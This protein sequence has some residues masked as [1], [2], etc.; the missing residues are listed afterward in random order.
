MA[1]ALWAGL[2]CAGG[3]PLN[4]LVVVNDNSPASLDAGR[5]YLERRG[6]PEASLLHLAT[7]T[8][9]SI[10][11][12]A[13]SN[14][15]RGPVLA[16]LAASG[17]SN[18]VDFIVFAPDLPYRVYDGA[19]TNY[20][21]ASLTAAL[22]DDVRV[23]PNA[24]VYGCD[25]AAD[26]SNG[27]YAAER[28]FRH[29]GATGSNRYYLCAQLTASNLD[30]ARRLIDRA[31]AADFTQPTS[32]VALLHTSDYF[33]NI[34]WPLFEDADFNARLLPIPQVREILDADNLSGRTNLIGF[35][36]GERFVSGIDQNLIAPGAFADHITSY[37]GCLFDTHLM[38]L[39]TLQ[40][41]I[42]AWIQAGYCGAYGTVV[43]P[44]AIPGKFPVPMLHTWYARGFSLGES[45][46]MSLQY[47]YQ[48]IFVGDPLCA[49]FAAPPAVTVH[50]LTPGLVVTGAVS[51]S[52]T[53]TAATAAARVDRIDLYLDG[54]W[55]ATATNC[56]PSAS[57]R[58][59]LSVGGATATYAVAAG[60]DIGKVAAG[61]AAAVNTSGAPVQAWASGDRVAL[62]YTNDGASGSGITCAA[63]ADAGGAPLLTVAAQA[64]G[65]NLLDGVYPAREFIG[66]AGTASNGD[67][68]A[69]LITLT[70]GAVV[71]NT[72]VASAGESAASVLARLMALVNSNAA[73]Q[74]TDGVVAKYWVP[75]A[76]A[77]AAL[78]ARTPG[79][80]GFN[81]QVDYRVT[82]AFPGSGLNTN[83][84]F[85]DRF[86]DNLSVLRARGGVLISAGR[87]ALGA[88]YL[89]AT[90]NLADG[91]HVLEAVACDGGGPGTQGR[92]RVPFTV[93]NRDTTC[94]ITAPA[95]GAHVWRG[96]AVT[97]AVAA[98]S[99]GTVT[100]VCLYAEGKWVAATSAPPWTFVWVSS[101]Y[102]AGAIGLQAR[103]DS[104]T[105]GA[106]V[107]AVQAVVVDADGD[108]DGMPDRWE[109][110]RFGSA[111][112]QAGG[113]DA[114]GDGAS[115][116]A[117]YIADT[118]PTHS[119]SRFAVRQLGGPYTSATARLVFTGSSNRLYRVHRQDGS[120]TNSAGWAAAGSN[121][122]A[123]A[124]G[125]TAWSD[126]PAVTNDTRAYRVRVR[127]P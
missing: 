57:N 90:T 21:F 65:T 76:S 60:D 9:L 120:L 71:T 121:D 123:G 50:G 122:F 94:T 72:A 49:P 66:L 13:F 61:L 109:Y 102:G 10:D 5:H 77:S 68:A 126:D 87:T 104:D 17:L 96:A 81:L 82:Q 78:Q 34:Q 53:G 14:E 110:E 56:P 38:P 44:C 12:V 113:G 48:G 40:M 27:Y 4:V 116:L 30:V 19:Y 42:L 11:T 70:N 15:I 33:R 86:N 73:L 18:Q 114:D 108:G 74:G 119:A 75:T 6:I 55:L 26:T 1:A 103:A 127:V 115:N 43:E 36:G 89:L 69:C 101:N 88:G 3:G 93:D 64:L 111:T 99:A 51:L 106:A 98:A 29:A 62:A 32:R 41:S 117:E 92:V 54:A 84:A 35:M 91:P 23:S 83:Y 79:P 46:W 8:N 85:V 124:A 125:D 47:P 112:N 37:G 45:V 25:V 80:Q 28:A 7:T 2:A 67:T 24:F 107:S 59:W 20:R 39:D 58:V 52:L 118:D 105:D 97:V 100:Q 63:G 31:A 95:P 16:C 22:F